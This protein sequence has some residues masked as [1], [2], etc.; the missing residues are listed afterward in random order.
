MYGTVTMIHEEIFT[1][2]G[3]RSKINTEKQMTCLDWLP[4]LSLQ[5]KYSVLQLNLG[6]QIIDSFQAVTVD[7]Y[8][9][10]V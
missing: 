8:H 2:P 4:F 6:T 3:T 7:I 5:G 1:E 9:L 10:P